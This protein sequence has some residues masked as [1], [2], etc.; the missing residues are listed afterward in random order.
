MVGAHVPADRQ[1][2]THH[3]VT[4]GDRKELIRAEGVSG[5]RLLIFITCS[6]P[7]GVEKN[8]PSGKPEVV[9]S[10]DSVAVEVIPERSGDLSGVAGVAGVG[11]VDGG[12]DDGVSG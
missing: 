10:A 2:R 12:A 11:G 8:R 3:V 9:L 7:I 4:L 5:R 6:I 1:L